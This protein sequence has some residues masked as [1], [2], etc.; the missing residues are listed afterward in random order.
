MAAA[1]LARLLPIIAPFLAKPAL[2]APVPQAQV[3]LSKGAPFVSGVAQYPSRSIPA[4][5]PKGEGGAAQ[6]RGQP[7]PALPALPAPDAL[8]CRQDR[9][10]QVA[11]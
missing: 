1:G 9:Q 4:K 11:G 3:S 8:A 5:Y 10:A 2:P 7:L 6:R